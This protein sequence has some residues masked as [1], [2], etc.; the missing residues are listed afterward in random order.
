[1][2]AYKFEATIFITIDLSVLDIEILY[3]RD[4]VFIFVFEYRTSNAHYK[5]TECRHPSKSLIFEIVIAFDLIE[6]RTP[7]EFFSDFR[8]FIKKAWKTCPHLFFMMTV[9][10]SDEEAE[11]ITPTCTSEHVIKEI[12]VYA[13]TAFARSEGVPIVVL[14]G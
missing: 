13:L 6:Y 7:F 12:R 3:M 9:L 2:S 5:F 11:I 10:N 14:T 8:E 1:M 4:Y